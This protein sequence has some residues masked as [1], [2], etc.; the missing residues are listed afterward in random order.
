M[1]ADPV[2]DRP[3]PIVTPP[4][5]ESTRI[6]TSPTVIPAALIVPVV[7]MPPPL[8]SAPALPTAI[9]PAV[10]VDMV[11]VLT[12]PDTVRVAAVYYRSLLCYLPGSFHHIILPIPS[13]SVPIDKPPVVVNDE[14]VI[15]PP[16]VRAEH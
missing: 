14:A 11:P 8:I 4:G 9:P 3:P 5:V 12:R 15:L 2:T 16:I 7:V 10:L 13:A 6:N 1:Y